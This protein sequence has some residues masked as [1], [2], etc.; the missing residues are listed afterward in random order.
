MSDD[1]AC[2]EI[3]CGSRKLLDDKYLNIS[4]DQWRGIV[5]MDTILNFDDTNDAQTLPDSLNRVSHL[6]L[7]TV[8]TNQTISRLKS[9]REKQKN[10]Q[11]FGREKRGG[12]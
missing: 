5:V 7:S 4:A 1:A 2:S 11:T 9:K 6:L 8:Q 3:S 10:H 12:V